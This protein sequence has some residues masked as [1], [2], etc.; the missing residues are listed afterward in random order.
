MGT[1]KLRHVAARHLWIQENVR[2]GDVHLRV[3]R[4]EDNP[5]YMQT[6]GLESLRWWSVVGRLPLVL[7][8]AEAGADDKD[9]DA[10]QVDSLIAACATRSAGMKL[11][12]RV[13]G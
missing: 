6:K 2:A 11:R 1:G 13:E 4:G 10:M 8:T 9:A 3:V 12:L 5:A 7:S